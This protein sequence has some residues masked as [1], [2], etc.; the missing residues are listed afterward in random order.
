MVET[1]KKYEERALDVLIIGGGGAAALAA[2]EVKRAGLTVG[3]VTK[4]S[5]LVGGAT[6]M[7][8]GG[9]CAVFSPGDTPE[10]FQSDILR[11]GQYLNNAKIVRRVTEVS[12]RGVFNLETHDFLL[13]RKDSD[14]LRTINH[15][16]GHSYPRGY[17]DRREAL[18][19]CHALSKAL[20]RNEI[21]LFPETIVSKLLV[22]EKRILGAVAMS[23]A[24][25]EYRVFKSKAVILATGGLGALYKLTTNSAVL[26]GDGFA[27]AFEA[28][29]ELVDMEMVQFFP[30][31]FPYPAVRR[32]KMIA[33][34]SWFGPDVKLL[35]GLGERYMP[36]YD[37][38]RKEMSTRDNVS[39]ANFIEIME[40]RGTKNAAIVV[41]PTKHDQ[42]KLTK[43]KTSIPHVYAMFREVFG[44]RAAEW[45]EPF[46]AIPSQHFFMGGIRIDE[47]CRTNVAGLYAVGEVS[48]GMHG[49]NR[50]S[51]TALTEIYAM[52]PVAGESAALYARGEDI[53]SP[54]TQA[55]NEEIGRLNGLFGGGRKGVRP[56]ELKTAVQNI[57]WKGLGPVRSGAGIE[58]AINALE[59]IRKEQISGMVIGSQD[60]TYN[61]DRMEAIEVPFMIRT[62]LLVAH[63]ALC[64]KESRGS[65]YRTDFP[66]K[67]DEEWLRNVVVKKNKDGDVGIE[68]AKTVQAG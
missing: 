63:A 62:G 61:R 25:G 39:R 32:G 56:F 37:P 19:V 2:L 6:I 18:G 35:N 36:R 10:T 42:A 12:A 64:R 15:G 23:L 13:D 24:S 41:D 68:T 55:I 47:A 40:G 45:E 33:V 5:G 54:D 66:K 27:L 57:M 34:C 38:E 49:A 53:I 1:D 26:T 60:R 9:T 59:R 8:A 22:K 65:H 17:L 50:L 16:E 48:G 43:F 51:G 67:N 28:G 4:E 31:A 30:I 7:A 52:G 3:L 44:K 21:A 14:T 11:S 20:M 58:A 29:A 46:E